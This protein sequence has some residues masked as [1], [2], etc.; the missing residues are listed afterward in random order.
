[1]KF[2]I[3]VKMIE[4]IMLVMIGKYITKLSCLMTMSPGM[5]SDEIF[6]NNKSRPPSTKNT[7]PNRIKK[8]ATPCMKLSYR[9][10]DSC[11]FSVVAGGFGLSPLFCRV[12]P[13]SSL[14]CGKFAFL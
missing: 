5:R 6:G 1:M 9:G 10:Y 13:F 11:D 14:F 4:I 8:R 3:I 7:M 2:K 12:L